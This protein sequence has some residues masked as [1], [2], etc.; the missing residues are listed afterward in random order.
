MIGRALAIISMLFLWAIL[1]TPA[2]SK[3]LATLGE[4]FG[5]RG[6]PVAN[7]DGEIVCQGQQRQQ[8]S[9]RSERHRVGLKPR[10]A[11]KAKRVRL[12]HGQRTCDP[13]LQKF[14][15]L[16]LVDEKNPNAKTV[17]VLHG[18]GLPQKVRVIK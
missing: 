12:V 15:G 1:I 17:C 16:K 11:R 14:V 13:F 2:L 5:C 3:D 8:L 18:G 7:S 9:E 10:A 4:D 6:S